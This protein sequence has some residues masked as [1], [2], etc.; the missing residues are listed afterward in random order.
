ME[1]SKAEGSV[2]THIHS[3]SLTLQCYADMVV[4]RDKKVGCFFSHMKHLHMLMAMGRSIKLPPKSFCLCPSLCPSV[5]A[6]LT[7]LVY[8]P[9]ASWFFSWTHIL[10]VNAFWKATKLIWSFTVNCNNHETSLPCIIISGILPSAENP[11]DFQVFPLETCWRG[12]TGFCIHSPHLVF[13]ESQTLD[14]TQPH[15]WRVEQ[16]HWH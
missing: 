14:N 16:V 4:P 9:S 2:G 8:L 13:V 1:S 3:P 15:Y 7:L 11:G 10:K 5:L 6:V 12:S